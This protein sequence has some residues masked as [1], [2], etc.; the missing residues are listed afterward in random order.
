MLNKSKLFTKHNA[1][2]LHC[3]DIVITADSEKELKIYLKSKLPNGEIFYIN[4]HSERP[5]ITTAMQAWKM[6]YLIQR[7]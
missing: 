7:G 6:A 1:D 3:G 5:F 2:G 4:K